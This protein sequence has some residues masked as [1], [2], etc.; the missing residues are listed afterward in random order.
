[1]ASS[2]LFEQTTGPCAPAGMIYK[3]S[4]YIQEQCKYVSKD[5]Y[6]RHCFSMKNDIELFDL[7]YELKNENKKIRELTLEIDF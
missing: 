3:I 7:I 2:L 4:Q 1:M 5:I 6:Q